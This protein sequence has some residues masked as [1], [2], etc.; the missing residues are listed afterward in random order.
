MLAHCFPWYLKRRSGKKAPALTVPQLRTAT[1]DDMLEL[2]A[3][4][5]PCNHR[6]SL[7]QRKRQESESSIPWR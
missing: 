1:M 6:A 2:V 3:W 7:A 5:Q 4:V